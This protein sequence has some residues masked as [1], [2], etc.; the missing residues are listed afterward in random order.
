MNWRSCWRKPNLQFNP[1]STTWWPYYAAIILIACAFWLTR[2]IKESATSVDAA[3]IAALA[4][5]AV[6]PDLGGIDYTSA[7]G[8]LSG[9]P[10]ATSLS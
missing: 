7:A 8:A 1:S 4:P 5:A 2:K 3:L 10:L 6:R 9:L